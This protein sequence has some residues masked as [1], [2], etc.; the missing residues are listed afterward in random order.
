M[1]VHNRRM[2]FFFFGSCFFCKINSSTPNFYTKCE[3]H[4][5]MIPYLIDPLID[6][7]PMKPSEHISAVAAHDR[8]IYI[9]TSKGSLFHYHLFE[10]AT[11]YLQITLISVGS[12]EIT[13]LLPS[14]SLQKLF[15]VIDRTLLV[16]QLPELSPNTIRQLKNVQHI[17][18]MENGLSLMII[19]QSEVQLVQLQNNS[20]KLLREF[21]QQ[22]AILGTAPMNN[23]ILLANENSYEVLDTR[24]GSVMPLFE[25]KSNINVSPFIVLFETP[26]TKEYLLTIASDENTS[27][28]QF[29]SD[30]GDVT[31]GTLTWLDSGYPRGGVVVDWPHTFAL[32]EKSIIISSLETL[33]TVMEINTEKIVTREGGRSDT[34]INFR[35]QKLQV[36]FLDKSLQEVTGQATE[37]NTNMVLYDKS[38]LF[39]IHQKSST[40]LANKAF[41]EAMESNEFDHFLAIANDDSL[42]VHVLKTMGA[43]LTDKDPTEMLTR[44]QNGELIIEPHMALRLLGYDYPCNVYPGL[45]DVVDM[46]DFK[47]EDATR[48]YLQELKPADMTPESRLLCYKLLSE[49]HLES[50]IA[51]DKWNFSSNDKKI[52]DVLIQRNKVFLVSQIYKRTTKLS[53]VT[54]AY[55]EFLFQYLD[56]SL[57]DDALDFLA[58]ERLDDND[59]TKLILEILRLNK[60][61]GYALMRQSSVYREVNKKILDE[62][63][64]DLKGEKD[65]ALLRIELLESSYAENDGLRGELLDL[66]SSTLVALYDSKIEEYIKKLH[67]EYKEMNNLSKHK[68]PKISWIDFVALAKEK[69][70]QMFIELYLK[71]FE[72]LI[73]MD[74]VHLEELLFQYHK[75]YINRDIPGLL[76]FA[77]YSTAERLAL[78]KHA[79][80]KKRYYEQKR[81]NQF[82]VNKEDLLLIFKHFL[83][84]YECE[85]VEPA[86]QHF[87]E[88][89]SSHVSPLMIVNL[90]PDKFP[91]VYLT[92]FLRTSITNMQLQSREK[93]MTKSII[94]SELS[95]TKHLIKDL[96]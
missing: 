91:L 26:S 23:L 50:L 6:D 67:D 16:F 10:D 69:D 75:L 44:R 83:N 31:R 58:N 20:W 88:S 72:L 81:L 71:S 93:V 43:F 11:D 29:I 61:K 18:L 86:I 15:L 56:N 24:S 49:N 36:L 40:L 84:L 95:R 32:F 59:Y 76:E 66:I 25:Y 21:K 1:T 22:G 14:E 79:A 80:Q 8:N 13:Q 65:Y 4:S 27:I 63:S 30:F 74:N 35:I 12:H 94:K 7:L 85:P 53:A 77:D 28:A 51:E 52:I 39:V 46:W 89:Y 87:V 5:F 34:F 19:K 78:G 70:Y 45:K 68:W 42:Y 17:C 57:V 60:E 38:K 62:L 3:I 48:R 92:K 54:S 2:R 82:K 47:D 96:S 64:D 9:G 41:H 55:K 90:L 37:L 73:N 33:E